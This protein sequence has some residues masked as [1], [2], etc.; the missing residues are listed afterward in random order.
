[1][2]PEIII[3][4]IANSSLAGQEQRFSKPLITVGRDSDTDID[5]DPDEDLVVSHHHAE[6]YVENDNLFIRDMGS[7]NGT[8]VNQR[9][10]TE[11]VELHP[12]DA[13]HFGFGGPLAKAQLARPEE[14]LLAKH[15]LLAAVFPGLKSKSLSA[16]PQL[17]PAADRSLPPPAPAVS[18]LEAGAAL[19][20][21]SPILLPPVASSTQI[22]SGSWLR[23]VWIVAMS[24]I[25]GAAGAAAYLHLRP[26]PSETTKP[27]STPPVV[28]PPA[29]AIAALGRLE[30]DGGVL[31]ISAP[32]GLTIKSLL[33]EAG[34]VVTYDAPLAHL[35][36]YDALKA[37]LDAA[38][39][40]VDEATSQRQTTRDHAAAMVSEALVA[41][42]QTG[43]P[44]DL[45]IESADKQVE[46]LKANL[47]VAKEDRKQLEKSNEPQPSAQLTRQKLV[48]QVV[49]RELESAKKRAEQLRQSTEM[50]RQQ[51]QSQLQTALANQSRLDNSISLLSLRKNVARATAQFEQAIIRAPRDGKVLRVFARPGAATGGQPILQMADTRH[52]VVMA[53]IYETDVR[54]VAKGQHATI[55]SPALPEKLHG[56]VEKVL[57][58]IERNKIRSIDPTAPEDLRVVEARIRLQDDEV[59][60]HRNVLERLINL[61]VHV[62][63]TRD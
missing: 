43:K 35:S 63:I 21:E 19:R 45:E 3:T 55:S 1:M 26:V 51:A 14:P 15:T 62:R 6:I 7:R 61:Q 32:V 12:D 34:D 42:R 33:I 54:F 27:I 4:H 56:E 31:S 2:E 20:P 22:R 37:E 10:I 11:P 30:P 50:R 28:E 57:W 13:I 18:A 25:F 24:L 38:N 23:V 16:I 48:E 5:F 17:K 41:V 40:A 36:T 58:T 49:T 9:R 44:L 60:R 52:L 46:L 59:N 8:Y 53:E 47:E 39:T 29:P